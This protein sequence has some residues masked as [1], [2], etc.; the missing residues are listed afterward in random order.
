M[1]LHS[2]A[3]DSDSQTFEVERAETQH[4]TDEETENEEEDAHIHAPLLTLVQRRLAEAA[5][6]TVV[7]RVPRATP[8]RVRPGC[9]ATESMV[10]TKSRI[11]TFIHIFRAPAPA[12]SGTTAVARVTPA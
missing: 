10:T 11:S 2:G 4:E 7:T 9:V 3:V 1:L 8:T 6:L 12:I 5:L